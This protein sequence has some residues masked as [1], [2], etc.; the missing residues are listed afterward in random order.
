MEGNDGIRSFVKT[1][2]S[3]ILKGKTLSKTLYN[4]TVLKKYSKHS[5]QK[6]CTNF[7]KQI[8]KEKFE[9]NLIKQKVLD[10][11]CEKMT[12]KISGEEGY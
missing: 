3:K 5:D 6:F 10:K 2:R 1:L 4:Q 12:T 11:L 7:K 8:S 9:Q